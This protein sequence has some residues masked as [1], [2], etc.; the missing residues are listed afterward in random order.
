MTTTGEHDPSAHHPPRISPGPPEPRSSGPNSV[1]AS[2]DERPARLGVSYDFRNPPAFS[3]PWPELYARLL[4]QIEWVDRCP[5]FSAISISE[6]H[7][8]ADGYMPSP[9]VAAAA[10]AART[11]RVEIATNVLQLPIHH[12]VRVAEDALVID[13]LSGG[14]LRLGVGNGYRQEELGGFGTSTRDR[15]ERTEEALTVLRHAFAG[16]TFSFNGRHW[17][18]PPIRVTPP[19]VRPGGPPIW[20]SGTAPAALDRA[21]RRGDGFMAARDEQITGYLEA[22]DRHQIPADRRRTCRTVWAIVAEDPERAVHE[23]A[24]YLVY[25]V[26]E[27]ID[28]GAIPMARFDDARAV[29]DSGLVLALDASAAIDFIQQRRRIGVEEVHFL[30]VLPGEPVDSGTERLAYIAEHVAP[31]LSSAMTP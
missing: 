21:A 18:I 6:H 30:A 17:S 15:R 24:P 1:D 2:I 4:D 5:A 27:Y 29:V 14:R 20:L 22:C 23:L 28:Y 26:N 19:P 8:A 13:A 10:I 12:P 3:Q 9:L 16:E 7:F 25:Y 31:A 11:H